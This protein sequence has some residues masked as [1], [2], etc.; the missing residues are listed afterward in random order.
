MIVSCLRGGLARQG[1]LARSEAGMAAAHLHGLHLRLDRK[2]CKVAR[3]D[4]P[5]R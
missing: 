5:G 4:H 2:E 1:R 3:V